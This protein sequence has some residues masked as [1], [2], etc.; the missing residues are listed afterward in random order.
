MIRGAGAIWLV[1]ALFCSTT[2]LAQARDPSDSETA[3]ASTL[4]EREAQA[5][6]LFEQGNRL[7]AAGDCERAAGYFEASRALLPTAPNTLNAAYCYYELGQL[8][9]ALT[10]YEE[11]LTDHAEGLDATT[12]SKLERRIA[13][14]VPKVARLSIHTPQSASLVIDGRSRAELPAGRPIVLLP[15]KHEIRV[16]KTGFKQAVREVELRAGERHALSIEL[17]PLTHRGVLRIPTSAAPSD[18]GIVWLDGAKVGTLPFEA[19]LAP[20]AHWIA[21]EVGDRGTGPQRIVVVEGQVSLL[22][23]ALRPLSGAVRIHAAPPD[24][25]LALDGIPLQGSS[26]AGRI[27]AGQHLL[28]VSAQGYATQ[29][30]E[31]FIERGQ[32]RVVTLELKVDPTHP[33]WRAAETSR[34]TVGVHAHA[35]LGSGLGSGPETCTGCSGPNGA[36]GVWLGGRIDYRLPSHI[37]ASAILG[38]GRLTTESSRSFVQDAQTADEATFDLHDETT[39]SGPWLALGLGYTFEVSPWEFSGALHAG[40]LFANVD[41][42]TTGS[43][44]RGDDQA[45]VAVEGADPQRAALAFVYPELEVAYQFGDFR[46]GLGVGL[47][48]SPIGGPKNGRGEVAPVPDGNT[49]CSQTP[50]PVAC[51]R[52]SSATRDERSVGRFV[53]VSPGLSLGWRF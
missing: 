27:T 29:R 45:R 39:V 11:L 35:L 6:A 31:F 3:P 21:V 34:L 40:V 24:A 47:L 2:A 18:E 44:S 15:G 22:E 33:R 26:F 50:A 4:P 49:S 36:T 38:Y 9:E 12:R 20:G 19:A 5:K 46:V 32:A 43:V 42:Q 52:S 16:I 30:L 53:L 17:R 51:A 13:A 23:P 25:R 7:R 8:D 28:Q 37:Q 48:I 1:G 10:L 41:L 14:I